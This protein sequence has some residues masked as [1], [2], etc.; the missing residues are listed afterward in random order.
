MVLRKEAEKVL[1]G[2]DGVRR[3]S[4]VSHARLEGGTDRGDAEPS[5][6]SGLQG[7]VQQLEQGGPLEAEPE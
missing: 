3:L 5:E 4:S 2:A 6:A 7:P 1:V